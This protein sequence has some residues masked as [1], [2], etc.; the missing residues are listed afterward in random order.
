M[1]EMSNNV[2]EECLE[3][4]MA[5]QKYLEY[6]NITNRYSLEKVGTSVKLGT[7]ELSLEK[8]GTST[9]VGALE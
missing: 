9:K 1:H 6:L 3:Y 7:N 5:L 2:R 4:H 8:V